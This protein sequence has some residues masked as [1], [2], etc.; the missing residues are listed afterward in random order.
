MKSNF[1]DDSDNLWDNKIKLKSL[2]DKRKKEEFLLL[3]EWDLPQLFKNPVIS[4]QKMIEHVSNLKL[5]T[6]F[7][8]YVIMTTILMENK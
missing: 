7:I 2:E 5:L 1:N 8:S 6:F 4:K 3:N